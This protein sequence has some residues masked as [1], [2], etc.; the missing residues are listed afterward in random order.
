M[1]SVETIESHA[2]GIG[3][4][5][6][7]VAPAA[8]ARYGDALR[9]WIDEGRA[10][11][12]SWMARDPDV[13][14]TPGRAL[15]DAKSIVT[16]GLS[17]FVQEPPPELWNDPSR[18]RI[19]RYA[20]G[21][22]YHDVMLPM[23]KQLAASL[24]C[25]TGAPM[26]YHAYVDTGPILERDI[27]EQ[28]GIGV[29]GKNTMLINPQFGSLVFLG[30]IITSAELGNGRRKTEDGRNGCGRCRRCLDACP[31]KAFPEPYVVD[32]R[33][34]IS[35]LTI[36]NKGAIPEEL[37]P[38][39]GNWIFGCDECQSVCPWV[40]QFSKPGR[41]DFLEFKE[42]TCVPLLAELMEMEDDDFR[43]RFRGTPVI[44]A[45]RR[46]LLRNVAVAL[47]NWGEPAALDVLE[48]AAGGAD[49]LIGE[50]AEWALR[51]I[52]GRRA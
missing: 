47:G 16:V 6:C 50:H 12:M 35:Y 46:G 18:G 45:K 15:P 37:R 42:E 4:D 11:G 36:E 22:D 20:W 51:R 7:G 24:A 34:C 44:R 21:P 10:A 17:Y 43:E 25:E 29:V 2:A 27:A 38:R 13:R 26:Q 9:R 33:R 40:K 31:T 28:A 5:F 32:S 49:S 30:E 41:M 3:F 23:L 52:R 14:T 8:P 1:I 39:M 48:K 19:S